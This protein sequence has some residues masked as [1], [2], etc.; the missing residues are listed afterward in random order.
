LR[1]K[2]LHNPGAGDEEHD[3][4]D[5]VA[6][7]EDAGHE[8]VDGPADL[9]VAAGGDGTVR[10]ALRSSGMP[11]T[12]IPLGSANNL[13]RS[14]GFPEEAEPARLIG[15]WPGA[16]R[17]H[18][19]IGA[20]DGTRFVESAGGGLFGDVL[21][22]AEDADDESE[23]KVEHGLRLLSE[24]VAEARA[25]P[26]GL[27]VDG[28]VLTSELLALVAMNVRE[29][30]PNVPLAPDADPGDGLLDVVLVREQHRAGLAGYVDARLRD[31]AAAPPELERHRGERVELVPPEAAHLHV[32]EDLVQERPTEAT[33]HVVASVTVLVPELG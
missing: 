21:S 30:G 31:S 24:A 20:L 18:F 3:E 22:L 11:V 10:K 13:A 29:I 14:L 17:E 23:D 32:D 25:R 1:V 9:V 28:R 4:D 6:A 7:I 15:G 8:V 12:V 27:V 5:L 19:D 16:R 26:W 33:A 2:L